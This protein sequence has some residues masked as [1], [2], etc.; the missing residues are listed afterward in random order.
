MDDQN[1]KNLQLQETSGS[2]VE[3]RNGFVRRLWSM[4]LIAGPVVASAFFATTDLQSP[5]LSIQGDRPS[6]VFDSYLVDTGPDPMKAQPLVTT[7]FQY[8]NRGRETIRIKSLEAQCSCIAPQATAMELLPGQSGQVIL[9]LDTRKQPAG[10]REYIVTVHYED[11]AP[12]QVTLTCK[13]VLP[14]K[15][16]EIEPRVL[17][18]MGRITSTDKDIVT[19]VDYRP[20]RLANPIR[21]TGVSSSIS[22]VTVQQAG[23]VEKDGVV[24]Q[25]IQVGYVD[26]MPVGAHKGVISIQTDDPAN[27]VLQM[28]VILGGRK[29]TQEEPVAIQPEQARLIYGA[30][31]IAGATSNGVQITLPAKWQFSHFETFPVEVV[32]T[33]GK[34]EP[35]PGGQ[36]V[37]IIELSLSGVPQPGFERGTI[38]LHA[39]DGDEAEMVTVPL[40]LIRRTSDAPQPGA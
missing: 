4:V 27:P 32:A 17:M 22:V 11:P 9:P 40:S 36:S 39:K 8:T 29:R 5:P 13:T 28:P 10:Q 21:I 14:E 2:A 1:K 3:S 38:T 25:G 15:Q 18:V 20:E 24:R 19:I 6:L 31:N 34:T 12:R 30:D 35:A 37:V 23:A 33:V 26:N 16:I 7:T